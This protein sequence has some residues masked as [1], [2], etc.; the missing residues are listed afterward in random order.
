MGKQYSTIISSIK[1]QLR[2]MLYLIEWSRSGGAR[3]KT[4]ACVRKGSESMALHNY[5][6][7]TY[8]SHTAQHIVK[9]KIWPHTQAAKRPQAPQAHLVSVR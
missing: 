8:S 3:L 7:N 1:E 9:S 2:R 4:G 5:Q 6:P